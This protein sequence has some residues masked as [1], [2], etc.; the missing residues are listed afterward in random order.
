MLSGRKIKDGKAK[1]EEEGVK[2]LQWG[3]EE[4]S[5]NAVHVSILTMSSATSVNIW[6]TSHASALNT[7][8]IN[9]QEVEPVLLTTTMHAGE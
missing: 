7:P 4:D 1:T 9:H 3:Q 6:D 5:S 2:A 8:G